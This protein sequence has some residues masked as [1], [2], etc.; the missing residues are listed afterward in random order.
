MINVGTH[1]R[2]ILALQA[3][4]CSPFTHFMCLDAYLMRHKCTSQKLIDRKI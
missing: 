3:K 2:F 1:P 4:V